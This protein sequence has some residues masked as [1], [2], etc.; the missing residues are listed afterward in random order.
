MAARDSPAAQVAVVN[1]AGAALSIEDGNI[2]AL[3][4]VKA[5][6]G[7]LADVIRRPTRGGVVAGA[8]ERFAVGACT[9]RKGLS[10]R[11]VVQMFE[12][13]EWEI[14]INTPKASA[15]TYSPVEAHT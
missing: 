13:C 9:E 7:S 4:D 3:I 14:A 2:T 5:V 1:F 10:L 11:H 8:D 6:V 12:N 15:P